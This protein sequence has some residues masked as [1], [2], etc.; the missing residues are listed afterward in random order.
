M[1]HVSLAPA[2]LGTLKQ[3]G[4]FEALKGLKSRKY[5]PQVY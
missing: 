3:M 2:S 1:K 5:L 4:A